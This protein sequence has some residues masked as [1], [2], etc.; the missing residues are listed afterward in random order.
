MCTE[1]MTTYYTNDKGT[2][3][4]NPN[5]S[6]IKSLLPKIQTNI[7]SKQ[8][9]KTT[10]EER[11]FDQ[12]GMGNTPVA[13]MTAMEAWWRK[14]SVRLRGWEKKLWKLFSA[15]YLIFGLSINWSTSSNP[16]RGKLSKRGNR[17]GRSERGIGSSGEIASLGKARKQGGSSKTFV[18]YDMLDVCPFLACLEHPKFCNS[19][20]EYRYPIS[21]IGTQFQHWNLSIARVS[22][23]PCYITRYR[24]QGRGIG[25]QAPLWDLSIGIGSRVL[26]LAA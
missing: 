6:K 5:N 16:S 1:A 14:W 10:S 7:H 12:A 26:I 22:I 20:V 19:G 23:P 8:R 21:G 15:L 18:Q 17:F 4:H 2:M 11:G 13:T 25:T 9:S 24:Y 3:N